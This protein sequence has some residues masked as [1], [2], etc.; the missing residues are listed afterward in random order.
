[1]AYDDYLGAER[2][3][4][5]A[6][7]PQAPAYMFRDDRNAALDRQTAQTTAAMKTPAA[8]TGPFAPSQPGTGFDAFSKDLE[9]GGT[10]KASGSNPFA[11]VDTSG[12][13]S[14]AI[15][16]L[17]SN[18]TGGFDANAAIARQ[19]AVKGNQQANEDLR[20]Q[21]ALEFLPG[22]GQAFTPVQQQTD[23]QTLGMRDFDAKTAADRAT[24]EQQ[25]LQAGAGLGLQQSGQ[26][27]SAEQ[28]AAALAETQRQ[29][30]EHLPIEAATAKSQADI[31]AGNLD[32]SKG[33]LALNTQLGQGE[34]GISKEKLAFDKQIGLGNLSL[35]QQKV[36]NQASQFA[37]Q[38]AFQEFALKSGMDQHT[39]DL[40][41]QSNQKEIERKW[42]TGERLSSE[43]FT[44]LVNQSQQTYQA[45]QSALDRQLQTTLQGNTQAFQAAQTAAAQAFAEKM[46]AGTFSHDEA[47]AASQQAFTKVMTDAG[48]DHDT[49]MQT[50]QLAQQANLANQQM[51][52]Q[53]T[54]H[55]ADL[56]QSDKQ[57]GAKLG[58]DYNQ[59]AA[60]ATE[61]NASLAEKSS[62]FAQQ[63][64]LDQKQVDAALQSADFQN[65]MQR[66]QIGMELTKNNP[67]AMQP[68]AQQLATTMGKALGL[69]D[70]QIAAGIKSGALTVGTGTTGNS[71]ADI[72]TGIKK[73]Q[74]DIIN[75]LKASQKAPNGE[76]VKTV[77]GAFGG[78]KMYWDPDAGTFSAN[79]NPSY[80]VLYR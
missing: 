32:V 13:V 21:A 48:F 72:V 51:Q 12:A 62:E 29:F 18:P 56:A 67:D 17:L 34:L 60:Q 47:M 40:A 75:S 10:A 7:A 37:T 3:R 14:G 44:T 19:N 16:R 39:A 45:A 4:M 11:P 52:L 79:P 73:E 68:F 41:W 46:Q 59:L 58:L 26:K 57:F 69:S 6:Q 49:A 24:A 30:N 55:M 61:F 70:D 42:T 53:E 76:Y 20:T 71:N 35:E 38:A 43:E 63:F 74:A 1:M 77:P 54:M 64:G 27:L 5:A 80:S 78:I 66:I 8:P 65:S 23:Q 9:A 31:A 28:A 33:Q 25:G 2:A 22:T 50:A 15:S 36:A